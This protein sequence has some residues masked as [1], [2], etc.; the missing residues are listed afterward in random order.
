MS[1][2]ITETGPFTAISDDDKK[3]A[4][5]QAV[6]KTLEKAQQD[7]ALLAR[8]RQR[9]KMVLEEYVTKLGETTGKNYRVKFIDVD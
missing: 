7:D 9:A 6:N 3:R 4:L 5:D 1:D 8:G 2:P